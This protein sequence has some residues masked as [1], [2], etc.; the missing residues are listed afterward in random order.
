MGEGIAL[1]KLVF[2]IIKF[3]YKKITDKSPKVRNPKREFKRLKLTYYK[4]IIGKAKI[5]CPKCKYIVEIHE[6]E[7]VKG[8]YI[9][10]ECRTITYS[11]EYKEFTY[12]EPISLAM[13]AGGYGEKIRVI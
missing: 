4:P 2:D 6:D 1:G 3:I 9:C 13:K 8:R 7:S 10:D 11:D 12:S 5:I